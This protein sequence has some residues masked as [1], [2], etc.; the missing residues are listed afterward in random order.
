MAL[1]QKRINEAPM[2]NLLQLLLYHNFLCRCL[3]ILIGCQH[4]V[5]AL[6]H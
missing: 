3:A 4:D 5:D 6:S 2:F 1:G